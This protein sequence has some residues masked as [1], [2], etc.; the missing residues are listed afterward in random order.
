MLSKKVSN[1]VLSTSFLFATHL[2]AMSLEK[3]FKIYENNVVEENGIMTR[4]NFWNSFNEN[5]GNKENFFKL[6]RQFR[7]EKTPDVNL[8]DY[9]YLFNTRLHGNRKGV[10]LN[11]KLNELKKYRCGDKDCV[12][13]LIETENYYKNNVNF[14][15]S[16]LFVE[17]MDPNGYSNKG[18]KGLSQIIRSTAKQECGMSFSDLDDLRNNI[19]CMSLINSDSFKKYKN[20]K[21]KF[22]LTA[23]RYHGGDHTVRAYLRSKHNGNLRNFKRKNPKT[24][25][26]QKTVLKQKKTLD[27]SEKRFKNIY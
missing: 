5:N 4:K 8:D 15:I 9:K 16:K 3:M 23:I 24:H 6:Y 7:D 10:T 17:G 26:Y 20:Y 13:Y 22:K 11:S 27:R 14:I 18:A 12:S 21:E 1:F 2:N 19:D 25:H